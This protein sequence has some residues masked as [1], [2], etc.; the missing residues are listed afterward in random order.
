VNILFL[1]PY[2]AHE[3]PSQRFRFEHYLDY[4]RQKGISFRYSPFLGNS[5]W[6]IFFKPGNYW[7]KLAGLSAG[8]ARRWLLM[9]TI[10]KYDFIYIHREAAPMGPPVFEWI[11]AKL[12]RKKIIY[13]F[14]D[15]IWIPV[16]SQYNK[17]ARY[18]KWFS[19]VRTICRWSYKVSAGNQFLAD[20]AAQYN[21]NVVVVVPTVVDT[22]DV[23]NR[24]QDQATASP[25]IGWTGTFS[26]LKFLDLV[27]P[28]LRRLQEQFS[29]TFV[30]IANRDPGLPLKNYRFVRW[31]KETETADLLNMHIGLMPLTDDDLS[32]GKCGFKAIQYMSLGIPAV[33]SPVGVNTIIVTDGVS[34][35][36]CEDS[37]EWETRL[38]ELLMN[39][40]LR[41]RMGIA[42]RKQIESNY[43]VIATR[44]QFLSLFA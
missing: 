1:A 21:R 23:H 19:K 34:G 7:R 42:A 43:S 13:D 44:D 2:P 17:I 20:Y 16:S 26:T 4:L 10:G 3:S 9:F 27:V 8:F 22:E 36:V 29:F 39:A 31:Q 14:D 24:I 18:F 12:Y 30:V 41:E 35:F 15:A 32:K 6:E 40:G 37:K 11:I 28:V 33:V 25:V 5:T 38:T